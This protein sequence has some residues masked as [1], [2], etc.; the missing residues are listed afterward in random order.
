AAYALIPKLGL[1]G[2]VVAAAGVSFM[3][4]GLAMA[5]GGRASA[6]GRPAAGTPDF[7]AVFPGRPG[8]KPP[9]KKRRA[10]KADGEAES[11]LPAAAGV[12]LAALAGAVTLSCEVAQVRAV[13]FFSSGT[14]YSF[15]TVAAVY[16]GALGLGSAVGGALV[17]FFGN[18][19]QGARLAGA[20]ALAGAG[21]GLCVPMVA[22]VGA[23]NTFWLAVL[24]A[25]PT[26][27][28]LGA[29]FP[30][31]VMVLRPTGE[32]VGRAVGAASAALELGSVAGAL[33]AALL[34]L[35]A[36]GTRFTLLVTGC[37]CV[38][39]AGVLV[40]WAGRSGRRPGILVRAL[41]IAAL[42]AAVLPPLFSRIYDRAVL[43]SI[44][45][46]YDLKGRLESLDEGVEAVIS[47]VS[48]W[49]PPEGR[50]VKALY[51]GR[52]MQAEDSEP[53]LRIEKLIG[54]LPGLLCPRAEGRGFHVGL[55]SGVSA[56]WGAAAAP[57]RK[58]LCAEIVPGVADKL[59]EFRPHNSV[60][61]YEVLLGDGRSLLAAD[62][63]GFELIVTDIVFPEDA[64]AG[65]L[66]SAEYFRLARG[67]LAAD[68]V[69]AHWLPLW[70]LS[71]RAFRSVV[72]AFLDV[73]PEATMWSG[74]LNGARPL[75]M[76]LG[77]KGKVS[78]V[79]DPVKLAARVSAAGLDG[80][81]LASVN[82]ASAE[83]VLSHFVAG[84]K[85]LAA[86]AGDA[87]AST[88]DLPVSELSAVGD[89]RKG[90]SLANL[91]LLVEHWQVI[92]GC[93]A[94]GVVE[95]DEKILGRVA[96]LEA[97]RLLLAE[98]QVVLGDNF[99]RVTGLALDKLTQAQKA[100]PGDPE[101]SYELW[102]GLSMRAVACIHRGD[103]KG[104]DEA[105]G[106]FEDALKVGPGRRRDYILRGLAIALAVGGDNDRALRLAREARDA[107]PREAAN[108]EVLSNV[109]NAAGEKKLAAE[110]KAKADELK[111]LEGGG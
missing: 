70:Q 7:D 20:L 26:A 94:L 36:L 1:S 111:D 41:V 92:A 103:R 79:L 39:A 51:V 6:E 100:A 106:L 22:S 84:P 17:W 30:L 98:A 78:A 88:D 102:T 52:K 2:S 101:I 75:V 11:R 54:A 13:A 87:A 89:A 80:E 33:L 109:A 32:R 37:V 29:V 45:K 48:T 53:W 65:G 9:G 82:L 95:W 10:P 16:I 110:A 108:W 28:P 25:G 56:A 81:Q 34:L 76:L 43:E 74:S 68:G 93:R 40:F 91:K 64:G 105:R 3:A 90:S 23:G 8:A 12:V 55:G 42:P 77:T 21:T 46:E 57:G 58:S 86:L 24:A 4:A 15:A 85:A 97:S 59:D 62:P 104:L 14:I 63:G 96:D 44:R 66:F 72:R 83:A 27:L 107:N 49:K 47:L 67:K 38:L 18:G 19:N 61:K 69:F 50:E 31:L 99:P 60:G 73:F 35:P 5:F 71:P